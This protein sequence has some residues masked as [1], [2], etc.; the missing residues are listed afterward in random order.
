M[1]KGQ[2]ERGTKGQRG[3][4]GAGGADRFA[5]YE[6]CAQNP[7]RDARMLRA[8]HGGEPRVL[9]EDFS[10][11]AAISRAWV[12]LWRGARAVA[13][14]HD[15]EPLA[16]A[17]GVRAVRV[18]RADVMDVSD[19]VDLIGVLNFSICELHTRR[20]LVRYLRHAR[21]RLSPGGALVVDIYGGSD[22]FATGV[23]TQRVKAPSGEVIRYQWEQRHAD[24]LSGR[25]VNAMHF[26]IGTVRGG[27]TRLAD[28]FV[29]DWRL[30]SVP[31]L[32]EAMTDAGFRLAEVYPR[33]AGAT[34]ADGN[35][36]VHPIGDDEGAGES[37][38]VYVVGRV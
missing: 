16:R 27:G 34:D 37:Y 19:P 2:R 21:S 31:E 23:I 9:G 4:A 26:S 32:R 20:A 22:A 25:V 5:L 29:Y 36:Y 13:V 7:A 28:A 24:A 18:R 14:D 3:G 11:T 38:V 8:I 30:W 33:V 6:L 12:S 17:R 35:L 10:G 1:G 15:A